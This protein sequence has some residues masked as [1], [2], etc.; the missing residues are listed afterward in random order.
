MIP[1]LLV[2]LLTPFQSLF[3]RP[4]WIKVQ[5]LLAGAILLTGRRTV[6]QVLRVTGRSADE[7]FALYHHVLSRAVWSPLRAAQRLLLML[8]KFLDNG[9]QPLVFG[10]DETIEL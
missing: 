2:T 5:I 1:P 4:S 7:R 3:R 8:L 10:I 6:T 9:K